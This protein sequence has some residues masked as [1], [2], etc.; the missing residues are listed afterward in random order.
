MS[1]PPLAGLAADLTGTL[2]TSFL[3]AGIAS[4]LSIL[5][6]LPTGVKRKL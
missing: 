3:M 4:L 1:S 2:K 5:S 6:L